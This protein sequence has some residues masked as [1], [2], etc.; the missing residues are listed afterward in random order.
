MRLGERVKDRYAEARKVAYRQSSPRAQV[1]LAAMR[2]F[3]QEK[4]RKRKIPKKRNPRV[5]TLGILAKS[6]L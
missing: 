4:K 1:K 3:A 2:S 5:G 6:G